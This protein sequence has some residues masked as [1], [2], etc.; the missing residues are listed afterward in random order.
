MVGPAAS[1]S[2]NGTPTSTKSAPAAW[3]SW[4]AAS[5]ASGVGWP[6]VRYGMS[7]ARRRP[8]ARRVRQRAAIG[9]SD[10]VIADVDAV[11]GRIGDLD[12][13]AGEVALRIALRQVGEDCGLVRC[14][15]G[16]GHDAYDGTVDVGVVRGG[17]VDDRVL[18]GTEGDGCDGTH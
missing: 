6:A 12:D 17:D 11:L 9:C 2:L 13:G 18:E 4:S 8:P 14:P 16:R 5:D 1:G 15:L 10:K 7:A 3:T